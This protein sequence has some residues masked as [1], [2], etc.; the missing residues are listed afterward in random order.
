VTETEALAAIA[1]LIEEVERHDY[2]H[3]YDRGF[4]PR[5][6]AEIRVILDTVTPGAVPPQGSPLMP[7]ET[8]IDHL[9]SETIFG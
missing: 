4:S 8:L 9:E 7:P 2:Q 3:P 6:A 5:S 1:A